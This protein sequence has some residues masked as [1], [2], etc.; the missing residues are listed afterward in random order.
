MLYP[1]TENRQ[2]LRREGK[3]VRSAMLVVY[4]LPDKG[5]QINGKAWEWT[6][7]FSAGVWRYLR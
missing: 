6:V 3:V 2:N 5:K 1:L 7:Y 4:P